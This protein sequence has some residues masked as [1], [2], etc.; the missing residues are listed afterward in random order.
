[1]NPSTDPLPASIDVMGIPIAATNL[2]AATESVL[3]LAESRHGGYIC[4]TGAHGIIESRDDPAFADIL[5]NSLF[6]TPDGMPNVWM[7]RYFHGC[8][9]MDRVYGP[10]LMDQ[11]FAGSAQ[12]NI[13]HFFYGG[14][15]GVPEQLRDRLVE[16]YP[17][18]QVVGT[19]SPPFRPLKE[20]EEAD[21][22]TQI[23]ACDPHV[24]WIGLSTPK[25]E[26]FMAA[27][28]DR[29]PGRVMLGVGAAFD[30]HAGLVPSAPGKFQR[31]GLEWF[32]RLCTEPRRL[33][34]R[35]SKIVPR[36]LWGSLRQITS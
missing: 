2:P 14:K 13:R 30:F 34:P 6:N 36:F 3:N 23:E 18:V 19:Y 1:M 8:Q 12:R 31:A 15:E 25:Q 27:W 33:W 11:V 32:Y 16:K 24:I 4:V 35:Y 29:L 20:S 10:D 7:G 28:T 22:L 17:G 5:K 9:S 21:L 26:K